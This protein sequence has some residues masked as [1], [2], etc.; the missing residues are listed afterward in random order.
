MSE[1][2]GHKSN[3]ISSLD[4]IKDEYPSFIIKIAGEPK[5]RSAIVAQNCP[6][7]GV[8]SGWKALMLYAMLNFVSKALPYRTVT[9][10]D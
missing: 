8:S 5:N 7:C 10:K 2:Q 4:R 6:D 9:E 1:I 3:E